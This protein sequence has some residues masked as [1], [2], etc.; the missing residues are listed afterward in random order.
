M[1]GA[2]NNGVLRKEQHMNKYFWGGLALGGAAAYVIWQRLD[3]EQKEALLAQVEDNYYEVMD[4]LTDYALTALDVVDDLM[5]DPQATVTE[6]FEKLRAGLAK[7][8]SQ[9]DDSLAT[10]KAK[11]AQE[12]SELREALVEAADEANDD[13]DE[14][15]LVID[16]RSWATQQESRGLT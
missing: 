15:D 3:D 6:Q 7:R 10:A 9:V 11:M 16:N 2:G 4:Y 12:T 8:T 5:Q 1:F 13:D 14:F